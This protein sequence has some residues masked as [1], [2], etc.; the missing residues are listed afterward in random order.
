MTNRVW[1]TNAHRGLKTSRPFGAMMPDTTAP[2]PPKMAVEVIDRLYF[3]E[4]VQDRE[5]PRSFYRTVPLGGV[6]DH[7]AKHSFPP[8]FHA[9]FIFLNAEASEVFAG[10][11]LGASSILP[12]EM[13]DSDCIT[14]VAQGVS[15]LA[16]REWHVT[17]D[18]ARSPAVAKAFPSSRR[19]SFDR[20]ARPISD[21]V[22]TD[23]V[24]HTVD[25]WFDPNIDERLFFSERA[26]IAATNAGIVRDLALVEVHKFSGPI[27]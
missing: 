22:L 1:M 27:T 7:P 18:V 25:V 4:L 20:F 9:G 16:V 19:Y 17:L 3:G 12:V 15:L 13:Y 11:R 8:I 5:I 14:A 6:G 10:L 23:S 24:D 21:V 2:M 26:V